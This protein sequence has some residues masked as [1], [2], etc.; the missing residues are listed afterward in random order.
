MSSVMS[1][2]VGDYLEHLASNVGDGR[3]RTTAVG[4][5]TLYLILL[6]AIPA[7]LVFGPLGA[8]GRPA[9]MFALLVFVMY[10]GLWLRPSSFLD[11]GRQP[12]RLAAVLFT[13]VMVASYASANRHLLPVLEKNSADRGIIYLLGWLGILLLAADGI[14]S[15]PA[16]QTVLRRQVFGITAVALLGIAEFIS[17]INATNYIRL[18]GLVAQA[19]IT[20]LM[21]RGGLSRVYSTTSQPIEFGA[22]VV[23]TVPLALHQARYA[24]PGKRVSRWLQVAVLVI[25]APLSVSRS[26]ILALIVVAIVILPTWTRKERRIAYTY[27]GAALAAFIVLV[28]SL[29]TTLANLIINISSDPSAQSRTNAIAMSWSYISQH[30]W[31]GHG[32]ATFLPQTY[33]FV[34]D[35]YVTSTI[36]T[37]FMGLLALIVLFLAGWKIARSARRRAVDAEGRHLAQCFAASVAAAAI[38]F[39]DYD[40]FAFT[41]ASGLLFLL[42][43][44]CG[45]YW[46]LASGGRFQHGAHS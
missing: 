29:I 3:K 34:D 28:P 22:V 8:A 21:L 12:I 18:P 6:M 5:L 35:Q 31:L 14:S 40:A 36:E 24:S 46:R 20:D 41:I 45:A 25:A 11:R 42:L 30:P 1:D 39:S 37:G 44:C 10:L 23:M 27:I 38:S 16:L 33:F 7:E 15:I 13:C 9:T 17:G 2:P 19:P 32:F 43:G 4:V 26:A